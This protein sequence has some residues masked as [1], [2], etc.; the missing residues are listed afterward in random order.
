MRYDARHY[1]LT[2]AGLMCIGRGWA[3]LPAS[4]GPERLPAGLDFLAAFVPIVV[5]GVLW[6]LGGVVALAAV[7]LATRRDRWPWWW[8][9][10]PAI[11]LHTLWGTAYLVGWGIEGGRGW[12]NAVTY[13][14][15]SALI[16]S[17][18]ANVPKRGRSSSG[19]TSE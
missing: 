14:G 15:T 10:L 7:A 16:A 5:L 13:L 9:F 12:L 2:V 6:M 18:L 8:S 17:A 3:Y 4:S 19:G 11:G 1:G